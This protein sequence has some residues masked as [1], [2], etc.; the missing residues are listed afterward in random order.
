[1]YIVELFSSSPWGIATLSLLLAL[2][3]MSWLLIRIFTNHS[4]LIVGLSGIV[5]M[6]LYRIV[7]IILELFF[8]VLLHQEIFSFSREIGIEWILE[9]IF[10]AGGLTIL[11]GITAHFSKRL[12]P[13]YVA[14]IR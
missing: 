13:H 11:Y 8:S 12:K 2:S 5:G 14:S 9:I 3:V 10:T 1:M 6:F 7:F 4:L